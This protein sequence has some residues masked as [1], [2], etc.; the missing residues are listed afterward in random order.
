MKCENLVSE[1]AFKWVNLYRYSVS[2]KIRVNSSDIPTVGGGALV[3]FIS[4][5]DP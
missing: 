1:F 3:Y 2:Y 4:V 5:V